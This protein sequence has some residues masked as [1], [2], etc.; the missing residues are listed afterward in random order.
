MNDL[1]AMADDMGDWAMANIQR[2]PTAL[3]V[4]TE[5][6]RRRIIAETVARYRANPHWFDAERWPDDV[7]A[8]AE[9]ACDSGK[10]SLADMTLLQRV[11]QWLFVAFGI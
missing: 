6:T 8:N 4:R 2:P 1:H 7:Y 5:E 11:R 10:D 9:M 3:P